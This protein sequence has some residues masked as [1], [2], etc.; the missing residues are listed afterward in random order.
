MKKHIFVVVTMLVAGCFVSNAQGLK[1][2]RINEVMVDNTSSVLD[3]YG[4]ATPWLELFNSNFAPLNINS[5]YITNDRSYLGKDPKDIARIIDSSTMY[6]VPVGSE[7]T[8]MDK[9]GHIVFYLDAKPTRGPL[10]TN[11]TLT[12]GQT[13]WIGIYDAGGNLLDSVS[14]PA[15]MQVN[16]SYARLEDGATEWEIRTADEADGT[17][18]TP[19]S[20]N[21]IVGA[22][23][24]IKDF[25][26]NDPN[27]FSMTVMAMCIVF[28]ALLVLCLCF[29]F[30]GMLGKLSHRAKKAEAMGVHVTEVP[31][32][33][34]DSGEEIAAITLALHEHFNTHDD[35][36]FMLTVKK[37]KRAYSPW[38]SKIY[39]LRETP[40][41]RR[42]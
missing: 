29:Y 39:G 40:Q 18:I 17:Y 31:K 32:T 13:N 25:A 14:V 1:A 5:V 26:E 16:Q 33:A 11:F 38:S 21:K 41:L 10:H 28:S 12:P 37:M 9:R 7:I 35:E 23:P 22:N 4:Q 6:A 20:A 30:I 3:E 27:G 15:S 2:L 8:K 24:R 42:R 34:H 36:S 19:G